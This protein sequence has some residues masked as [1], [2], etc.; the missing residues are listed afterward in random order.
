MEILL[1]RHGKPTAAINPR[2]SAAGFANWVRN[3]N[4]SKVDPENLPPE[5][6]ACS[7]GLHFIVA[8][9]LARSVNSVYLCLNREPDL[10]LKQ[11]REMNIPRYKLP[12]V[13]KAYTWLIISRIF[14]LAGF[15]GRVESFKTAKIRAKISAKQ[16]QELAMQH[17]KVAFFGHGML[18]KYIAKELNKLGWNGSP[19]DKKYWSTIKL[20]I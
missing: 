4:R 11:L 14:W 6:L 8:S 12:F 18:N 2:L 13:F 10:K 3:Y 1:I 16:L 19:Q 15:S 5:E 20:T 7:L 9:D 17:E